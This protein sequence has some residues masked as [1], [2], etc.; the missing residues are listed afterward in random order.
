MR[1]LGEGANILWLESFLK[2]E[3]WTHTHTEER[4]WEEKGRS[5]CDYENSH[6]QVTARSLVQISEV[7]TALRSKQPCWCL[8]FRLVVPI[9]VRQ[10]IPVIDATQCAVLCYSSSSKLIHLWHTLCVFLYGTYH[11]LESSGLFLISL[12][13]V[14]I[15]AVVFSCFVHLFPWF[16]EWPW[17][18]L[19]SL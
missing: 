16:P 7:I 3:M 2:E 17:H 5:P 13:T 19:Y 12:L 14:S 6:L 18:I 9:S 4:Q 15:E 1:S 11:H 8:D 10:Q